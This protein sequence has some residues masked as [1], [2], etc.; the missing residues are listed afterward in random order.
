MRAIASAT[1]GLFPGVSDTTAF[2]SS[3]LKEPRADID[4]AVVHGRSAASNFDG[5]TLAINTIA[6]RAAARIFT[7]M[8]SSAKSGTRSSKSAQF[9]KLD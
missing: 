5:E 2:R 4:D 1:T 6:V 7:S 9:D 8:F 3:S